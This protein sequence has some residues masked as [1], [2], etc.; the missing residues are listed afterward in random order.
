MDIDRKE[1]N[2]MKMLKEKAFEV[3]AEILNIE[4]T[5][6]FSNELASLSCI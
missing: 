1:Y 2:I 6:K 4:D 5:N 3:G